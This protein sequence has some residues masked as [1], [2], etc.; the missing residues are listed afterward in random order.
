MEKSNKN[1]RIDIMSKIL[2]TGKVVLEGII[3]VGYVGGCY[4]L[5]QKGMEKTLT[6]IDGFFKQ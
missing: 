2:K 1:E 4:I 6:I 3:V 5:F